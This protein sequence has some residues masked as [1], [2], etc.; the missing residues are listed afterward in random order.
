VSRAGQGGYR[1]WRQSFT[2][3]AGPWQPM[4]TAMPGVLNE[5][6]AA[7]LPTLLIPLYSPPT[8]QTTRLPALLPA[9][10]VQPEGGHKNADI[11]DADGLPHIG[12]PIW[13][14]QQ[15]YTAVNRLESEHALP[16]LRAAC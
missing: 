10:R 11:I 16:A 14:G 1:A 6:A 4:R 7:G 9:C 3:C 2:H 12:A 13:P 15:Y 5:S 8:R